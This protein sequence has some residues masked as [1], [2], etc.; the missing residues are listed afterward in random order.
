[1]NPEQ[2]LFSETHEW[3]NVEHQGGAKV[4]VIGISSFAVEQLSDIV[5]LQLPGSGQQVTAG[6][7]FGEIESV[8]AVS[9]LYS[10]VTGEIVAVNESL[11]DKLE[12]LGEDP[13]D[14]GWMIKV[15]LSDEAGLEK[16]MSYEKYQKQC[17]DES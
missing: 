14:S 2:L 10:P 13:Y 1:V 16:L 9:P 6:Q 5:F 12:T 17:A 15:K 11:R 3:V 8:K 7:E 4:A